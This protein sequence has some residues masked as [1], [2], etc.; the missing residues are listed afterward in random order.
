MQY[1]WS[2]APPILVHRRRNHN[3][4]RKPQMDTIITKEIQIAPKP[5]WCQKW[6]PWSAADPSLGRLLTR[7]IRWLNSVDEA[8]GWRRK[9]WPIITSEIP[10]PSCKYDARERM[11]LAINWSSRFKKSFSPIWMLH[12]SGRMSRDKNS[13][14]LTK[15]GI[16]KPPLAWKS[17][18]K[19]FTSR[20]KFLNLGFK[21]K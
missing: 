12:N 10:M 14:E 2:D 20:L 6:T 18:T 5:M 8:H 11:L 15:C 1:S 7:A 3:T 4:A 9:S 17:N 21:R 16:C 13:R 19:L